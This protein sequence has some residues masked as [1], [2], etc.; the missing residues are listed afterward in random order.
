M[1]LFLLNNPLLCL[2]AIIASGLLLGAVHI[3]GISLGT[4]G[5]IFSSLIFGMLGAS[6][7]SGAGSVGIVLFVY[8]V[9]I[10]VGPGFFRVFA[11]QGAKLAE[12]GL[13]ITAVGA[14]V[15]CLF[16]YLFAVPSDLAAGVFAG[17]LTSTPALA[18][19]SDASADPG[20]V[21]V[22]YGIAYPF[23]VIGVVLFVQFLP[24]LFGIRLDKA[25]DTEPA[26][27]SP[28]V[29]TLVE[30]Q[31]PLLFGKKV[32]DIRLPTQSGCCL[33]RVL[34]GEML[35]PVTRETVLEQGMHVLVIGEEQTVN[36]L[37]A[38]L[39][40][41]S[42]QPFFINADTRKKVVITSPN[43]VG[44]PLGSLG[45]LTCFGLTVSRVWRNG[46]EFV[47]KPETV[48]QH[49]DIVTVVG[50]SENIE[51]FM[52]YAGHR[53][54][55]LNETDLISV[56][57]GIGAGLLLGSIPISLTGSKGFSL[58]LA[59]GPLIAGL[60]MSHFG[61]IGRIRGYVPPAA[62][63]MMMNL[64]LVLFLSSAGI[65]AGAKLLTILAAHGG[66][67]IAMAA[68]VTVVPM[69]V[70]YLFARK[71]L[72]LDILKTLGGICGGMT[73][74]PGLGVLA[75]SVESET[76]AVSYAAAYPI[77]LILMT[78]FSQLILRIIG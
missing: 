68:T 20:T 26:A 49:T 1:I 28:I 7:P 56:S 10:G 23:G 5:V 58:G 19:A 67:L 8:A 30:I 53:K 47:P 27:E 45:L 37:I 46:V 70:G 33:S 64:G 2:F 44:K 50:L 18:A 59:G 15:T 73:S 32:S 42:R 9:G 4:S 65:S 72:K 38:F 75:D 36:D 54:R 57:V 48:L 63:S 69:L 17:S 60:I 41:L 22:G 24:K 43:V 39:G 11:K 55:V 51:Q 40:V 14:G 16:A 12:L 61:K 31:N 25:A 6:I 71:F 76:P 21:S 35:T 13:V 29:R 78:V 62:R 34:E 52:V 3:K 77:S 74:T 66:V